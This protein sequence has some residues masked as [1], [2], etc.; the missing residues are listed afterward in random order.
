MWTGVQSRFRG[1]NA[2]SALA[3]WQYPIQFQLLYSKLGHLILFYPFLLHIIQ[4]SLLSHLL[5]HSPQH[6][7]LPI[8]IFLF[9][10]LQPHVLYKLICFREKKLE[11]R[12][13]LVIFYNVVKIVEKLHT[14]NIVHRLVES[15]SW[16]FNNLSTEKIPSGKVRQAAIFYFLSFNALTWTI[17]INKK[18]IKNRRR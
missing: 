13:T 12:E 18:C 9:C 17:R 1:T 8:H 5:I 2:F 3:R 6:H 15:R 7:P 16:G 14:K 10:T 4:H 11:E